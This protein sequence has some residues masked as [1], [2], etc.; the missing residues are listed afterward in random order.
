MKL[1]EENQKRLDYFYPLTDASG[2]AMFKLL[3]EIKQL[4]DDKGDQTK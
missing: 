1:N 3:L 2:Y 4:L